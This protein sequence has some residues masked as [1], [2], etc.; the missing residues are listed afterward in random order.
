M[1]PRLFA[2]ALYVGFVPAALS[3]PSEVNAAS[4]ETTTAMAR[5][6]FKEGV[7]F[8]DKGQYELARASFLQAYALKK[9]PAV[10]L[11]LAWS[12]LKSSHT[13]EAE[14]YFRQ[15]L[16]EGKEITEKQRADAND[17]L[18]QSRAKLGRIE[19]AAPDGV[20]VTIDGEHLS[21]PTQEGT[22]V[23]PGFHSVVLRG[24]DGT[25]DTEGVTVGAGETAVARY[26]R[27]TPTPAPPPAAAQENAPPA[28]A[29]AAASPP[30]EATPTAGPEPRP[31]P[32][33]EH[34]PPPPEEGR[35]PSNTGLLVAGGIVTAVAVASLGTALGMLLAKNAAQN[36]AN[37]TGQQI[38]TFSSANGVNPN[39]CQ[40]S[41]MASPAVASQIESACGIWNSDNRTV[42]TDATIGNITLGL[43]LA[44]AAGATILWVIA[45][46]HSHG[47]ATGE[48]TVA[49]IVDRSTAGLSV[50][51]SF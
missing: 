38:R 6:R 4:E 2:F 12:C 49:P 3:L 15:F 1:N 42:D 51:G 16:A 19:V 29:P 44:G 45:A 24:S 47:S 13:R 17:G 37:T 40:G 50:G 30:P 35:G 22:F 5:A 23:E 41:I 28:P 39:N 33:P 34:A 20:D 14:Q 25:V 10:L 7:E 31:P 43:G 9:H 21:A 26:T 11:N 18:N 46:N 48:M 36:H 32:S 27:S 8:Y